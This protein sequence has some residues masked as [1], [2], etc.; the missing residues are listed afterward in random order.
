MIKRRMSC[1]EHAS[2]NYAENHPNFFAFT[3]RL[4]GTLSLPQIKS[5]LTKVQ[6]TFP[7]TRMIV[8]RDMHN[9][10][11]LIE[12]PDRKIPIKQLPREGK[13]H[14]HSIFQAALTDNLP[15]ID[16]PLLCV[17]H[18]Q[19]KSD[20][21]LIL[22]C[23]H[24]F[25]DGVALFALFKHLFLYLGDPDARITRFPHYPPSEALIPQDVYHSVK[26]ELGSALEDYK[27]TLKS[28]AYIQPGSNE[29]TFKDY[30]YEFMTWCVD[31]TFTS[32][33]IAKARQEKTTVHHAM[34]V[35]FARAFYKV[36]GKPD[37]PIRRF[38]SPISLRN[39]LTM[40]VGENYT[41]YISFVKATVD[42]SDSKDFWDIA[43]TLKKTFAEKAARNDIF[44]TLVWLNELQKI[45]FDQADQYIRAPD[46]LSKQEDR[47]WYDY[48]FSLSNVGVVNCPVKVGNLEIVKVH[49]P[50]FSAVNKERVISFYTLAD[51]MQFSF[52]FDR[53]YFQV[54]KATE[55]K[56][57]AIDYLKQAVGK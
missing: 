15:G 32:Q 23:H 1:F 4:K 10:P 36:I 49:G 17:Y 41:C 31:R 51:E 29:T 33:I 8:E 24:A 48:D 5:A 54:E 39:R 7:L 57:L 20:S 55:I 28:R 16:T 22:V 18:L 11:W 12:A 56:K 2:Y 44:Q 52:E 43:R 3:I 45:D 34:A 13:N 21:D 47:Q 9:N 40:D 50:S 19:G 38:Q 6:E 14:W 35:A 46:D 27:Q 37:Q 42:C 25:A 26:A 53:R 30:R